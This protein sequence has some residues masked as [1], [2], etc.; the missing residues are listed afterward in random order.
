MACR[1]GYY[2]VNMTYFSEIS[3]NEVFIPIFQVSH[4][5]SAYPSISA[6]EIY[7]HK[8]INN[9]KLNKKYSDGGNIQLLSNNPENIT[10]ILDPEDDDY[11][12]VSVP[13]MIFS[14]I[15]NKNRLT[16]MSAYFLNVTPTT[17]RV[18]VNCNSIVIGVIHPINPGNQTSRYGFYS[19]N[20][21][22]YSELSDDEVFEPICL[23]G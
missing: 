8:E 6:G 23:Y 1:Y 19:L 10:C 3:Q 7:I 11:M 15:P 16:S 9:L 13:G 5:L 20:F 21:N 14:C 4:M 22:D 17:L 12:L 18:K 2:C